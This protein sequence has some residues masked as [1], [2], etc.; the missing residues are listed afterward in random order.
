MTTRRFR[1][2]AVAGAMA[3]LLVGWWAT[4]TASASAPFAAAALTIPASLFAAPAWPL[5]G[6]LQ[7]CGL[8]A[9]VGS[10]LI[11]LGASVRRTSL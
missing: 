11:A 2:L 1:K 10:A 7:E 6:P 4:G 9:A 3:L 8:T 5:A